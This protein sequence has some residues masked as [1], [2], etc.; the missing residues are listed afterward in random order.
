MGNKLGVY[1]TPEMLDRNGTLV[2]KYPTEME[3]SLHILH[4]H[5]PRFVEAP[6]Q[7]L[8]ECCRC[9]ALKP[10]DAFDVDSRYTLRH[11]RRTECKACRR[12][13]RK[14]Q[15]LTRHWQKQSTGAGASRAG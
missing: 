13:E 7:Q 6:T 9:E 3:A 10:F 2:V 11:G 14:L 12:M 1:G 4:P 8:L 15:R 5:A